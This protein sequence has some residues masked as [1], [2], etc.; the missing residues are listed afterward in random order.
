MF[1]CFRL[2]EFILYWT[3]TIKVKFN[4]DGLGLGLDHG[5]KLVNQIQTLST[6]MTTPMPT[7]LS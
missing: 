4:L 7:I 1:F 6:V 2:F 3:D 5:L